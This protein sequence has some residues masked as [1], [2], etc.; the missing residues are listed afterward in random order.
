MGVGNPAAGAP[1][2]KIGTAKD[3]LNLTP[4]LQPGTY[5]NVDKIFST[6]TFK[7]GNSVYALPQSATPLVSVK[8]SPDGIN[9][10]D[11]DDYIKRNNVAGLL[12]IK[13]G[14]IVLERYAQGNTAA[15]KWTS[16]SV[17]KSIVSTLVGAAIQDGKIKNINDPVTDYLPQ[18]HGT[19]YEGVTVR[20][21]LQMSSG[22]GWNEDYRDPA[23]DF[24]VM[25]QCIVDGK[26]GC[27]NGVLSNLSRAAA[28]GTQFVYK[29]GETYLEGVVLSAALGGESLSNYLSRKIWANMGMEADGYW[30]LESPDGMEFGG[31]SLSM[32]L[33]D[34]GRFGTFILNNGVV[35]GT[36]VLPPEWVAEAGSP[37]A[38]SPQCGYGNLYSAANAGSDHAYPLGY[39][40]NWWSFPASNWGSWD[41]LNDSD[42][43][44]ADALNATAPNFPNLD[45]SFTAQGVFGQFIYVN[46]KENIVA[47][48]WSTWKD[49]WID[50]KEYET[51][52]FLNAAIAQLKR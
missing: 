42:L 15:S 21:L 20:E 9:T 13:D 44:G 47:V 10:Y 38:D 32:T 23:S 17:G 11:I 24:S 31:G 30:V 33:R 43:W 52:S 48:V 3:F 1:Y 37:A 36:P 7:R 28:P 35:N 25:F 14:K 4:E 12:I 34:Y 8:Y 40:Y 2:D 5:R 27:I 39:G 45:G 16:F 22:A 29:T 51:L 6:R 49:P 50:P 19:A 26:A 41:G 18:M 46:Q